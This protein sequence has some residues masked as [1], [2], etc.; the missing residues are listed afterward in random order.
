[1]W[2]SE[3]ADA[4]IIIMEVIRATDRIME[5]M[6]GMER[7]MALTLAMLIQALSRSRFPIVLTTSMAL[8]IG[9]AGLIT[10]GG[11]A[12]GDGVITID[13][14]TTVTTGLI[15][16][17]TK[18]RNRTSVKRRGRVR[19]IGCSMAVDNVEPFNFR[20]ATNFCVSFCSWK[21]S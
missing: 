18:A 2:L 5:V 9:A 4:L 17:G 14:G 3:V 12:I 6:G 16:D 21:C 7:V 11:Q 13:I 19:S 8:G 20:C 1:L 10:P 15:T